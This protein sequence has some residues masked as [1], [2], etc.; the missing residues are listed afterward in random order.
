MLAKKMA[1]NFTVE[2]QVTDIVAAKI[3]NRGRYFA[4]TFKAKFCQVSL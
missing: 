3:I 1:A 4:V 2:M